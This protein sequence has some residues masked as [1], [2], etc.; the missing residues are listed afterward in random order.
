MNKDGLSNGIFMSFL[1]RRLL[2]DEKVTVML[3]K[4]AEG[5]CFLFSLLS[6]ILLEQDNASYNLFKRNSLI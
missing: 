4:V 2:E 6:F 3:D 5:Q 1:T